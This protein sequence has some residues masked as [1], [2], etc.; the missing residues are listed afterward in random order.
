MNNP[1]QKV[2]KALEIVSEFVE[3]YNKQD[4]ETEVAEAIILVNTF[5]LNLQDQEYSEEEL[6]QIE[7]DDR[8]NDWTDTH[9]SDGTEI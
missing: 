3:R 5:F 7:Q 4:Q 2:I 9:M 8:A 6:D 1:S